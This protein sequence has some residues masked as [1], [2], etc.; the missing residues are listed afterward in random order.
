MKIAEYTLQ[1]LAVGQIENLEVSVRPED[2]TAYAALVGDCS[3]LHVDAAF[4]RSR[5]HS[6]CVAHG[7]LIGGYISALVGTKLPGRHGMMQS[8]DLQ[9]RAPLIP[10]ETLTVQ[11]EVTN[12]STG[13]G[14]VALKI[15]VKNAAGALLATGKVTSIIREPNTSLP[16]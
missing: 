4:A 10:P 1:S 15:T 3:P 6:A 5:G 16:S 7:M 13:T 11:G 14:Q 8:C 9:F 2:V 12:I